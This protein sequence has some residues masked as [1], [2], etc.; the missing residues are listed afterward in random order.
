MNRRISRISRSPLVCREYELRV[1]GSVQDDQL[2]RAH[3]LLVTR[4][5][6]R[7]PRSVIVCVVSGHDKQLATLNLL[8]WAVG[9]RCQQ[10]QPIDFTWLSLN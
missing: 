6:L 2:F 3:S 4:T 1:R 9:P 5:K 8:W 10:H 7:Q